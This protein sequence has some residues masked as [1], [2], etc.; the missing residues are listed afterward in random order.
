MYVCMYTYI[1][2]DGWMGVCA[3]MHIMYLCM[4]ACMHM[5]ACMTTVTQ[6]GAPLKVHTEWGCAP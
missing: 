6:S 3:C 4:Y 1:W 5:Y 2:M